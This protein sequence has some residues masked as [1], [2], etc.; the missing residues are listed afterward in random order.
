MDMLQAA[1]LRMEEPMV[2]EHE[3]ETKVETHMEQPS[4]DV[5]VMDTEEDLLM[6]N[7]DDKEEK[8]SHSR[9]SSMDELI[10]CAMNTTRVDVTKKKG[11]MQTRMQMITEKYPLKM[12]VKKSLKMAEKKSLRIEQNYIHSMAEKKAKKDMKTSEK[13][14]RRTTRKDKTFSKKK[15]TK[16]SLKSLLA[17]DINTTEELTNIRESAQLAKTLGET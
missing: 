3:I 15:H 8:K 14:P 16:L 13:K 10:E 12:K 17:M 1:V 9:S 5:F 6:E 2:K 11:G 7:K 4:K